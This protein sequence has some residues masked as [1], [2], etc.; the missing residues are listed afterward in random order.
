M[1]VH[2]LEAVAGLIIILIIAGI[3]KAVR[4]V[5]QGFVGVITRFGEF[6]DIKN[7]GLTFI[8]PF[9]EV[10]KIVDVRETPR[11]GDRQQVITRDNVA[12]IVNATIFSQVVD[13]RLALFTNSDYL[14]SVDNLARTSVR[15][16]FGSISLD[17]AFSQREQISTLLQTQMEE[18]TDKWGVR[19]NRVEVLE[20]TPPEQILQAMALQK[21]AD[22]EKRAK[23]LESEGQQQSA[24]N[25]A[26]GQRQ[27]AIKEAEGAQQAAILRAEGQRQALILEAEGR[28]QAIASVYAAIKLQAPDPT[29]VAILQLDTLS[30]FAESPNTKLIIPAESAALLGAAQAIKSVMDSVPVSPS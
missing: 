28:A 14:V 1:V 2:V 16:V 3:L 27:A 15:A 5:Q 21:Q 7:P 26:D 24:V 8:I 6:K 17:E 25:V 22:Q 11:T 12:V 23:I 29:L 18:A 19:I 9:I 30:K 4:I 10:M 20:I 13:V